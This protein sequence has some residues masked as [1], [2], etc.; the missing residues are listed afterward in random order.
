VGGAAFF[1]R[2]VEVG[3]VEAEDENAPLSLVLGGED[4]AKEVYRRWSGSITT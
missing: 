2:C 3:F 1:Q 4:T